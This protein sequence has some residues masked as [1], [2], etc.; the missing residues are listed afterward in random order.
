MLLSGVNRFIKVSP[1]PTTYFSE[2]QNDI[3]LMFKNQSIMLTLHSS[4]KFELYLDGTDMRKS[5]DSLCGIVQDNLNTNPTNGTVYLFVNKLHNKIKILH[6]RTG[7]FVLYYKRL[8]KGTFELPRYDRS[9]KTIQLSYTQLVLLFDGITI[10][11]LTQKEQQK[12]V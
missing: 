1:R 6:W 7:G 4:L 2:K 12:S 9:I 3:A 5:F 11:N 10:G 8:E